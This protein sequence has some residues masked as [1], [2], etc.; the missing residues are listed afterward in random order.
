MTDP[1]N[2]VQ[3]P[4]QTFVK[5]HGTTREMINGKTGLV[6]QYHPNRAR[7]TILLTESQDQVSLKGENLAVAGMVDKAKA[8]YEMLRNNPQ[9]RQQLQTLS[10]Q[11]YT[12]TGLAPQVLLGLTGGLFAL[13]WYLLGFSKALLLATT[14]IMLVSVIGPDVVAQRGW[15]G[16]LSEAPNRW[17]EIVQT[18]IPV[19]GP[20]IASN[21]MYLRLFTGLLALILVYGIVGG[22]ASGTTTATSRRL[23]TSGIASK[24]ARSVLTEDIKQRYYKLGFDDATDAKTFGASLLEADEGTAGAAAPSPTSTLGGEN[25]DYDEYYNPSPPTVGKKSPLNLSTAFALFTIYRTMQP[26]AFDPNGN[27]S[28][29]LLRANIQTMEVWRLGLLGFAVYRVVAAFFL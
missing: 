12:A 25:D 19:I 13:G 15:R 14:G 5:V 6:L 9:I 24:S 2:W 27:F 3:N 11:V 16:A 20:R 26:M 1:N 23:P 22:P 4:P 28:F 8:Y 29:N 17:R 21:A 18:Q 10:R 7:Y